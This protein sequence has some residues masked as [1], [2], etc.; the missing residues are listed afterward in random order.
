MRLFEGSGN[1]VP[2][3]FDLISGGGWWRRRLY[4]FAVS[5]SLL[6]TFALGHGVGIFSELI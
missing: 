5:L 4:S 6:L 2:C 1:K 3:A